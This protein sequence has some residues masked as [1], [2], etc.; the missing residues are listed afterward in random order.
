MTHAAH[1]LIAIQFF[2]PPRIDANTP[3]TPVK[4]DYEPWLIVE[5]YFKL[6]EDVTDLFRENVLCNDVDVRLL[7]FSLPSENWFFC[8]VAGQLQDRMPQQ[9]VFD[10]SSK[11]TSWPASHTEPPSRWVST[12]TFQILSYRTLCVRRSIGRL[13]NGRTWWD[14]R[15]SCSSWC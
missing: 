8:V 3:A 7:C 4:E 1:S 13:H 10:K 9:W 6:A 11:N 12:R 15:S 5:N 2:S 14:S